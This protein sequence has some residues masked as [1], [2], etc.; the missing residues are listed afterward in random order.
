MPNKYLIFEHVVKNIIEWRDSLQSE[1]KI[2]MS[3][4]KL[5]IFKLL[6]FIATA[7]ANKTDDGLLEVFDKFVAMPYGPVELDIYNA[8]NKIDS[9]KK[10]VIN[11]DEIIDSNPD[12]DL[13][14]IDDKYS[15]LIKES[16]EEIKRHNSELIC[17]D[18]FKLVNITHKWF[19]WDITYKNAKSKNQLIPKELLQ[20]DT[21]HYR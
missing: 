9:D 17:Y 5:K 16:I 14:P 20:N 1:S 10:Y 6:F 3:L 12:K 2:D 4:G 8:L 15:K 11:R 18:P 13:P 21:K 19:S 7:K